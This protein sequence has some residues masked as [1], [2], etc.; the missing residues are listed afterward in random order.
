[1]KLSLLIFGQFRNYKKN[2][3]YNLNILNKILLEHNDIDVFILTDKKIEGNYSQDNEEN[4][5]NIF[6]KFNIINIKFYYWE[7]LTEYHEQE[8]INEENYNKNCKHNRGKNNFT[9]NLWY[10]RYILNKLKNEYNINYDLNMFIR[11]FD[12]NINININYNYNQILDLKEII[13]TNTLLMSIDTLFIGTTNIMNKLFEFGQFFN[14]Y[15]DDIWKDSKL[16]DI[17]NNMDS[18]L[19]NGKYTYCSE[20]QI[21]SHIFY[22]IKSFKNIRVDFNNLNNPINKKS[23]FDIR[24][25]PERK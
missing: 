25:D 16:C 7:N 17:F 1:M 15:H 19:Y 18:C 9:S 11:L 21:F 10:R 14:L 8:I 20:I 2:L 13:N 3:E 24:L 12:I 5:I 22:N 4:I 6:K 23:I